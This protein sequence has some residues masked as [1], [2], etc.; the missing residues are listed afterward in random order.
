LEIL[1]RKLARGAR[2]LVRLAECA[3][4]AVRKHLLNHNR[5]SKGPEASLRLR[6]MPFQ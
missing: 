1:S 3:T 4:V 6:P 2:K 5:E